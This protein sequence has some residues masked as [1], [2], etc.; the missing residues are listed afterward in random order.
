[1][2]RQLLNKPANRR[3]A[4][5]F[6]I[7]E[8][9]IVV[10][11]IGVLA[12]IVIVAYNGI[13]QQARATATGDALRNVASALQFF[14]R[15]DALATWPAESSYGGGNPSIATVIANEPTLA[16]SLRAAPSVADIPSNNWRY[17]NDGDSYDGCSSSGGGINILITGMTTETIQA[18]DDAV[19]DGDLACGNVRISGT[20]ILVYSVANTNAL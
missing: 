1:M 12:A 10:V 15:S 5:G 4:S 8:L 7:V 18:V 13:T 20:T 9:L 2:L 19:D 14:A 16:S 17:D 6:T 3:K 11:V